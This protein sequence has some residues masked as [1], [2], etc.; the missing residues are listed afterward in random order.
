MKQSVAAP[1]RKLGLAD[2]ALLVVGCVIGSGI[3]RT[4]SVV[5][6]R[7]HVPWLILLAWVTGGVVT[8][9]GAFV[10]GELAVRRP[11]EGGAYAYLRDAFHPVV[12]FAYGWTSLLALF[13]GSIAASA[14]LFDGYFLPL[15]GLSIAPVFVAVL[16]LAVLA[17]INVLGVRQGSNVQNAL[18]IL[19]IA[20][21]GS[22]GGRRVCRASFDS[23]RSVD[24]RFDFARTHGRLFTRARAGV[25]QL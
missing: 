5:A 4:P 2:V 15:T 25:V 3:F 19:K 7:M 20:A 24:R 6:Q 22:G 21:V 23:E 12:A 17:F 8:L 1:A 9:F 14:V 10:L 11:E 16:T 13:S 18:T